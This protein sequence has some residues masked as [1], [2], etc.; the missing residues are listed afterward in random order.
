M[1]FSLF[2]YFIEENVVMCSTI[3]DVEQSRA[4]IFLWRAGCRASGH[5]LALDYISDA[6]P[7]YFHGFLPM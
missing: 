1:L 7:V 5:G 6:R 3:E 4:D 2:F